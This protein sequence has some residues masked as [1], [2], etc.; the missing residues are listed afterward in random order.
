M[1]FVE[2]LREKKQDEAQ[3]NCCFKGFNSPTSHSLF[4]STHLFGD[5]AK[6]ADVSQHCV[7]YE[8]VLRIGLAFMDVEVRVESVQTF[9]SGWT[10]LLKPKNEVDPLVEVMTHIVTFQGL[11]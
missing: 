7:P 5:L 6:V 3:E 8:W 2:K 9:Y 4:C 11:W 10:L 1:W